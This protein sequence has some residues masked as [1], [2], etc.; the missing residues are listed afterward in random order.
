MDETR[1][2]TIYYQSVNAE[3]VNPRM[4]SMPTTMDLTEQA[5]N[6]DTEIDNFD[7]MWELPE[8]RAVYPWVKLLRM[9]G[10]QGHGLF[11]ARKFEKDDIIVEFIGARIFGTE[12]ELQDVITVDYAINLRDEDANASF[13]SMY[14]DPTRTADP[15]D[16][17]SLR[18]AHQGAH[19]IN[20]TRKA[21]NS[22]CEYVQHSPGDDPACLETDIVY[23]V[24]TR[25]IEV[26]DQLL[27]GTY[28]HAEEFQ[29][30]VYHEP[31]A[32]AND[33]MVLVGMYYADGNDPLTLP[34]GDRTKSLSLSSQY[35]S[36]DDGAAEDRLPRFD[37]G[38]P[39]AAPTS[40]FPFGAPETPEF[41][42][43]P[44]PAPAPAPAPDFGSTSSIDEVELR[45]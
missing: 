38:S 7:D 4:C 33:D 35:M 44:A 21:G 1:S 23:V 28:L 13:S 34:D 42:A 26:G 18:F 5:D 16:S 11:A 43:S 45:F 41:V 32:K 27:E 10:A 9:D 39:I 17:P 15:A 37:G 2:I 24:A 3:R 40:V 20:G 12:A 36:A 14:I 6:F 19:F 25:A 22:N 31:D 30:I 29:S 8:D